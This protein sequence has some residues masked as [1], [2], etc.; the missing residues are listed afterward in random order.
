MA[1]TVIAAVLTDDQQL[2][3]QEFPRP[4]VGA[5]D[6]LLRVEA[7][8]I[9]RSDIEQF[10]GD[11]RV[12]G[13]TYPVIPGH[14][15]LGIIEEIGDTA[16]RRWGVAPGDRVAV[17]PLIPC[18]TCA[19]C[20][21]G[22]YASCTARALTQRLYSF[23]RADVSPALWGG[24]AQ[25]MYLHPN[26]IVHRVAKEIPAEIAVMFNPLGAGVKWAVDV[27]G[28]RLGDTVVVFGAGQRGLACTI[29]AKAVGARCVIITDLAAAQ[30]KLALAREFGADHT[31]VA[32]EEDVVAR[33][34]EITQGTFADVVV[35]VSAYATQPVVDAV[36]VVKPRGTIVLTGVKGA[37]RTIPSFVSDKVVL[38]SIT[39]K[40]VFGVDSP[41]YE[42][43]IR[44]IESGRYPLARMHSH[45]FALAEA[46]TAVKTLARDL[47]GTEPTHIAIRPE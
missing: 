17:E 8:G 22:H 18:G 45:D 31:I 24:Y 34:R 42:Q 6:A 26:T 19:M 41:A 1:R 4:A 47:P 25:Y 46:A 9:C 30:Y 10:R 13:V 36:E 16:A 3:L 44:I 33:V 12:W 14:E 37:N 40:G 7:C 21:G 35:D 38:K 20:L 28:T 23:V 2:E 32:D 15:P 39:I 43:A 27:G 11:F 5:D 29:A